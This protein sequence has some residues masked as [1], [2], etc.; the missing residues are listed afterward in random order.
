MKCFKNAAFTLLTVTDVG[1]KD[2]WEIIAT[3]GN[4]YVLA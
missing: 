2:S 1:G 4:L 3:E